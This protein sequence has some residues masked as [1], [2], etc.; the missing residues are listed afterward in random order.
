MMTPREV[1]PPF[2]SLLSYAAPSREAFNIAVLLCLRDP[3]AEGELKLWMRFRNDWDAVCDEDAIEILE[4]LA[5]D[6]YAKNVEL[7]PRR[8]LEYLESTFSNSLLLSERI[9]TNE[10]GDP[11]SQLNDLFERHVG[12][13]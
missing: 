1:N 11:T 12:G 8:L 9:P 10:D 4:P 7:G 6:L 3:D 5:D 2:Y 13:K